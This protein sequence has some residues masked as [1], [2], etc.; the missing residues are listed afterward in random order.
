[1]YPDRFLNQAP[2][3]PWKDTP[4]R[5]HRRHDEGSQVLVEFV[6]RHN[7]ARPH[8][9]NLA[10]ERRIESNQIHLAAQHHERQSTWS[11]CVAVVWS[12][13]YVVAARVHRAGFEGP[14]GAWPRRRAHHDSTR[15]GAQFDFVRESDPIEKQFGHSDATGVARCERFGSSSSCGHIV[16]TFHRLPAIVLS[17]RMTLALTSGRATPFTT[18][19]DVVQ[20]DVIPHS[21]V[22]VACESHV[23]GSSG[24]C[25]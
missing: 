17:S 1:M 23:C 5:R 10:A 9:L 12:R 11:N 6:R 8:L 21:S 13:I 18:A 15:F 2:N 4:A 22:D 20:R 14:A 25:R 3:A 19:A 7:D 16:I 24:P